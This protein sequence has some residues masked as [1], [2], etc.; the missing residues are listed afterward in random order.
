M[1]PRSLRIDPDGAALQPARSPG[2]SGAKWNCPSLERIAEILLAGTQEHFERCVDGGVGRAHHRSAQLWKSRLCPV[3]ARPSGPDRFQIMRKPDLEWLQAI[4]RRRPAH[5]RRAKRPF[6]GI[7]QTIV[8]GVTLP[9]CPP[10]PP[11]PPPGVHSARP[12]DREDLSS[13]GMPSVS[14]S[15]RNPQPRR[16][17]HVLRRDVACRLRCGHLIGSVSS[18]RLATESGQP[19]RVVIHLVVY[20]RAEPPGCVRSPFVRQQLLGWGRQL[21]D[22]ANARRACVRCSSCSP[23]IS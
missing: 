1:K 20:G 9:P 8:P 10:T 6:A 23:A 2:H 22:R 21:I 12:C 5:P 16:D 18:L 3:G 19:D 13:I 7:L 4:E 17:G 11:P 15:L 14:W